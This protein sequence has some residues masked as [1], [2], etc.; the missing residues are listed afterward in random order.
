MT[1]NEVIDIVERR[2][3]FILK[4]DDVYKISVKVDKDIIYLDF[5]FSGKQDTDYLTS[6]AVAYNRRFDD[7][8]NQFSIRVL[9]DSSSHNEK[10]YIRIWKRDSGFL[11]THIIKED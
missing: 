7:M 11:S 4:E 9:D 10:G 5:L 1:L 3:R 2:F 8:P 6:R